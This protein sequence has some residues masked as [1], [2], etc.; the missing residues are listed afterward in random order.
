VNGGD[1]AQYDFVAYVDDAPFRLADAACEATADP[2]L[3][4]CT[5]RL[6]SMTPGAHRLQ[7]AAAVT[8]GG[9]RH[10]GPRSVALN[11]LVVS[12][13]GGSVSA[14]CDFPQI[15]LTAADGTP[16]V[17]QTLATGLSSPSGLAKAPDG[18]VFIAEREGDVLVWKDGV[19][20]EPPALRL[21]DAAQGLDVGLLGIALDPAFAQNGKVYLAYTARSADGSFVNRVARFREVGDIFGENATLLEDASER[22]PPRTPRIHFGSDGKLYVAFPAAASPVRDAASYEGK[23]L[24]LNADGT[25]PRD[26]PRYSPIVSTDDGVPFAFSWQ[27][28]TGQL[29]QLARE[30]NGREML[31]Q[32]GAGHDREAPA[33]YLDPAVDVS[34]AS[35]YASGAIAAFKGDLFVSALSGRQIRRMRFDPA[36]PARVVASERLVDGDFGRISD[37]V[38]GSDGALYFTTANRS[39]IG[40]STA[41]DDRL[42]RIVPSSRIKEGVSKGK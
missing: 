41:L 18:R 16:F 42:A 14:R 26:N 39:L 7:V 12:Q 17:V 25:T 5:A 38:E 34:G 28:A 8:L 22:A 19:L 3:F 37:I 40:E 33:A 1:V 27:P 10:E 32:A 35:F 31:R 20:L 9:S 13:S 11:L 23:L 2:T 24:R 4:E 6:P 21:N 30:P 36:N 29:W 15:A